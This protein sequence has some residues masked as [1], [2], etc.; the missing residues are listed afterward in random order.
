MP[1]VGGFF[2]AGAAQAAPHGYVYD[3]ASNSHSTAPNGDNGP[4]SS[5]IGFL[6]SANQL[7]VIVNNTSDPVYDVSQMVGSIHFPISGYTRGTGSNAPTLRNTAFHTVTVR[8]GGSYRNG[9]TTSTTAWEV[10]TGSRTIGP[11]TD[12]SELTLEAIPAAEA[13]SGVGQNGP[14]GQFVIGN[15][16]SNGKYSNAFAGNTG[17]GPGGGG[18]IRSDLYSKN[19]PRA[20]R[21]WQT[22]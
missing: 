6:V 19:V 14:I 22:R 1:L 4:Y 2:A 18:I 8:S 11:G 17:G 16:N 9:T 15:A 20:W 7:T 3:H 13:N 5:V 12:A 21:N 10:L